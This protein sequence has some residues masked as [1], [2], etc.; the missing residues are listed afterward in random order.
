MSHLMPLLNDGWSHSGSCG[1]AIDSHYHLHS[2]AMSS[3][4][5][6]QVQLASL[7]AQANLMQSNS[8][9][10]ARAE[11]LLSDLGLALGDLSATAR[12]TLAEVRGL[13]ASV[14]AGFS[15]I[16]EGMLRQQKALDAISVALIRPHETKAM[17]LRNEANK[18]LKSGMARTG[19]DR[20]EDFND[21]MRLFRA[22]ISNPIGNQDYVVWFHIG[23]LQWKHEK[24][25]AE[26]AE[27]VC[28]ASRLSSAQAD[29]YHLESLRHL[30]YM[31]YLLGELQ[32]AY[33]TQSALKALDKSYLTLFDAARYAS[34]TG[35]DAEA[36]ELLETCIKMRPGTI[37]SMFAEDDFR[38]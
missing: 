26:A 22:T 35:R 17:E 13:R 1:R 15:Q 32:G 11:Q 19:R 8:A 7:Q 30:A 16:A 28:R 6:V 12:E 2:I 33:D 37:I 14:T 4:D 27:S 10:Y 31:K 5:L 9:H 23:W 34:R 29:L 3:A 24:N 25:L 21:A 36:L 18:W 20:Q 38:S